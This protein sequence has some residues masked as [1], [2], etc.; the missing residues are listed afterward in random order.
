MI[1]PQN[2]DNNSRR[3]RILIKYTM[4]VFLA[5]SITQIATLIARLFHFSSVTYSEILFVTVNTLSL[6]VLF[7]IIISLKKNISNRFVNIAFFGQFAV[8]LVM[9]TVW[10]ITLREVRV[11]ALFFAIMAL[12]FLLSNSKFI[13]SISIA[14][15]AVV[16]QIAGSYF[17]ISYLKQPGSF[18]LEVFYTCCFLPS[19]VFISYL[20]E[21]YS[22]QRNEVKAAKRI[23]EQ[24]RDALW[25]EMQKTNQINNELEKAL[26]TI[27]EMAIHDEL[28]GLYNRRHLIALLEMEKKR[29]D[30]SGQCFSLVMLDI[31]H[32]KKVNDTFGHQAGDQVLQAV[33]HVTRDT[34][35]AVDFC[36]RY[37][38]EEFMLILE[39]TTK[40]GAEICAERLRRLVESIRISDLGDDFM[41]TVSLGITEYRMKEELSKTIS[42]SDKALY[43]AKNSGRNRIVFFNESKEESIH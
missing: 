13:Q 18:G 38:G 34:L 43:Q 8:W 17:A 32:F 27:K 37:G 39:Q 25:E 30:R 21:Q 23:A 11:M 41:V 20:S 22:R 1:S 7:I 12:T 6:T 28:T 42:R 35:R 15:S 26:E 19:A 29:A 14:I 5:Y 36:G 3:K 33:A 10:V 24:N 9:Y 2:F 4:F 16:I 40:E 31:D